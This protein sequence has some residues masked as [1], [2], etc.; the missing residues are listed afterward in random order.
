MKSGGD[1]SRL[2]VICDP[3]S[4]SAQAQRFITSFF[5][6]LERLPEVALSQLFITNFYLIRVLWKKENL[7]LLRF[8]INYNEYLLAVINQAAVEKRFHCSAAA[9]EPNPELCCA[10]SLGRV[11]PEQCNQTAEEFYSCHV[12]SSP[13]V[14]K[15]PKGCKT[16]SP[17]LNM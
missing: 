7:T 8:P 16:T 9:A 15:Q 1:F 14:N 13:S 10:A 11:A 6:C 17:T 12:S 4:V 2:L 3:N 5:L